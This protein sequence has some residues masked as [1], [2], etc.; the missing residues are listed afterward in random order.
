ME[1]F[2]NIDILS[3]IYLIEKF[4]IHFIILFYIDLIIIL[5][6]FVFATRVNLS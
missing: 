4:P 6:L 5:I 3:F 2:Y 1:I